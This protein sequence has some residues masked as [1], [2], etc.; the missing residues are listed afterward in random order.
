MA[1]KRTVD[2][3]GKERSVVRLT[4]RLTRDQS[5]LIRRLAKEQ[6]C[7]RGE[8]FRRLLAKAAS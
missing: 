4:L 5:E 2:P 8:V 1:A 3:T 7:S 6:N